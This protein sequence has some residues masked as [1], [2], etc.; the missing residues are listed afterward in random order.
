MALGITAQAQR[1]NLVPGF[2]FFAIH[3]LVW[4][5]S[6]PTGGEACDLSGTFP[7]EVY[8]GFPISDTVDDAGFRPRYVRDTGGAPAT[9]VIQLYW[10]DYDNG[11]DGPLVE[12][13]DTTNVSAMDGQRWLFL[14]R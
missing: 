5:N 4:D 8:G 12:V 9:G 13:D 10:G 3:E 1:S 11:N 6:Y 7:S 2:G 14:G